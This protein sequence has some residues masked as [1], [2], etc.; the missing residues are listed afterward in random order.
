MSLNGI[1]LLLIKLKRIK[2]VSKC[3]Y[4]SKILETLLVFILKLLI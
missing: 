2:I 4:L 1:K 3:D